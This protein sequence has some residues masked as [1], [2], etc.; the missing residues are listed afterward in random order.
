MQSIT[1][2]NAD[3]V[4][5]SAEVQS[6]TE[7]L[8]NH[9]EWS[10][11]TFCGYSLTSVFQPIMRVNSPSIIGYEGLLRVTEP[12]GRAMPPQTLFASCNGAAFHE[13]D[14]LSRALHAKNFSL[15]A[16]ENQLLFLNIPPQAAS[17]DWQDDDALLKLLERHGIAPQRLCI[18][19]LESGTIEMEKLA[20]LV[21]MYRDLGCMVALDDFGVGES[22]FERIEL[23][24][25]DLVKL[26]RSLLTAAVSNERSRRMLT[27]LIQLMHQSAC[28]VLVEGIE[29]CCEAL[30]AIDAGAD[31]L[32]GYYLGMPKPGLC[33][34]PFAEHL[35]Q[36][37]TDMARHDKRA[38]LREYA[39]FSPKRLHIPADLRSVMQ[40]ARKLTNT[41]LLKTIGN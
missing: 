39:L 1:D 24:K 11:D 15:V 13:V 10:R 6:V 23:L 12:G 14:W 20:D 28:E 17:R 25:P 33:D 19:V 18:E 35:L 21:A 30:V 16:G 34:D 4:A 31:Y 7:L 22:N 5:G 3:S 40:S 29:E 32:Q 2:P 8:P 38:G 26:D 41:L 36:Q 37:L 9:H 27:W